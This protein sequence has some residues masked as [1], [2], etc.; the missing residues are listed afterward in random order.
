MIN[1]DILHVLWLELSQKFADSYKDG[2][3]KEVDGFVTSMPLKSLTM[4]FDFLKDDHEFRKWVGQRTFHQLSNVKYEVGYEEYENGLRV[5]RRDIINHIVGPYSIEAFNLGNSARL[6]KPRLVSEA[7]DNGADSTSLCYDGQP[8]FD[9]QHPVGNDPSDLTLVSNY[10]G[11]TGSNGSGSGD[12]GSVDSPWYLMDLSR[13]IKPII[14][15]EREPVRFYSFMDL[16]DP[17]VFN[18]KE[19]LFAADASCGTGYGLWQTCFRCEDTMTV[20]SVRAIDFSMRD[21]RGDNKNENGRSNNLG[22]KPTH[23][24]Y[25]ASNRDRAELLVRSAQLPGDWDTDV[26]DFGATDTMKPNPL[27]NKYQLLEVSWLP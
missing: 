23:L 27:Y 24:V 26:V 14:F 12:G 21:L 2:E 25:G 15:L 10:I 11:G 17:N 1:A 9:T 16:K 5:L 7:L 18:I 6:L 20:N 8:F 13:P 4:R 22:I 3:D 19:F